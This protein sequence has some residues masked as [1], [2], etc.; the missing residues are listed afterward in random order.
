MLLLQYYHLLIQL[1]HYLSD[2]SGYLQDMLLLEKNPSTLYLH[3]AVNV[4][5]KRAKSHICFTLHRP[6]SVAVG[7]LDYQNV[8]LSRLFISLKCTLVCSI[9]TKFC[10]GEWAGAGCL[11]WP[12]FSSSNLNALFNQIQ[13][14]H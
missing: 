9:K 14:V 6:S 12:E 8:L 3:L 13:G 2:I 10:L 11:G 1:P 7:K 4:K 5:L